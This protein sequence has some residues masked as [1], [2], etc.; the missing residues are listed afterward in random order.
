V[1]AVCHG[2]CGLLCVKDL[3]TGLPIVHGKKVRGV[4]G[5]GVGVV[6][7]MFYRVWPRLLAHG[8]LLQTPFPCGQMHTQA[9]AHLLPRGTVVGRAWCAQVCRGAC[10][11][12][13]VPPRRIRAQV[14]GFSNAEE[15]L[16]GMTTVVPI[17]LEDKLVE[18]VRLLGER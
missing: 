17:S 4:G 1:A 14:A 8:A 15:A 6:G 18:Q 12:V 10:V 11:R 7:V 3:A 9:H 13:R 16:I 2:P 5:A